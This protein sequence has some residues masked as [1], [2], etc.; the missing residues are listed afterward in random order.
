MSTR[1]QQ[2]DLDIVGEAGDGLE[3]AEMA[4]VLRPDL[5]LMD[6]SMPRMGGVEA[7]RRIKADLP[8]TAVLVVTADDSEELMLGAVRAGAAGYVLKSESPDRLVAAVVGTPS[9]ESP[10]DAGLAGRLVRR[11]AAE[12]D[13]PNGQSGPAW[14]EAEISS[15]GAPAAV[16]SGRP[17]GTSACYARSPVGS[18][19]ASSN[20]S[21]W[22]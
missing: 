1:S 22:R 18:P 3:A 10:M 9:G 14:E 5:V 4:R 17:P 13:S 11:L 6:L 19:S 21:R 2:E 8:E 7:T 16:C 20:P 15:P 12:G